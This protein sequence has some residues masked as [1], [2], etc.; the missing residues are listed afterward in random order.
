V[1]TILL[2]PN[3]VRL[4]DRRVQVSERLHGVLAV[5]QVMYPTGTTIR[6]ANKV[7]IVG[8]YTAWPPPE[9]F[10]FDGV[11]KQLQ[12]TEKKNWG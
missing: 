7:L 11:P 10:M 4:H 2:Y 5:Y 1:K 9:Q 12:Y 6:V 3:K 8:E